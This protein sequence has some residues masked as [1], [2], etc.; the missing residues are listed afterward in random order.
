MYR[1]GVVAEEHSRIVGHIMF[2]KTYISVDSKFEALLLAP[3]SVAL[4]YR[5]RRGLKV[6]FRKFQLA[7]KWGTRRFCGR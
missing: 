5:N 7:K 2:T 4:E 3:L 6:S 1:L